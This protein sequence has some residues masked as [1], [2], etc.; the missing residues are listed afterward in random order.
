MHFAVCPKQGNKIEGVVL[1][2]VC[3]LNCF[4]PERVRVSNPQRLTSITPPPSLGLSL[5]C[6]TLTFLK[7]C[8][9]YKFIDLFALVDPP[10]FTS[11]PTDQT[12]IE[13][14]TVKFRCDAAG[15]PPPEIVWIKDGRTVD[16]GQELNLQASRELSGKYWCS[17]QNGLDISVNISAELDVQCK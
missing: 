8:V 4:V 7:L 14:E 5:H 11:E 13:G 3:I 2:R 1:N 12:V 9:T 6:L 16:E 17:V 10:S 15:N